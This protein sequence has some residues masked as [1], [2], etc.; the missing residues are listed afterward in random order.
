MYP[1]TSPSSGWRNRKINAARMNQRHHQCFC[2]SEHFFPT[3]SSFLKFH[4]L[5]NVSSMW[6]QWVR[7]GPLVFHHQPLLLFSHWSPFLFCL[8]FPISL[9]TTQSWGISALLSEEGHNNGIFHRS[10]KSLY[11]EDRLWCWWGFFLAL[12]ILVPLSSH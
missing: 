11:W 3:W 5:L 12:Y 8:E 9:L 2:L 6:W 1:S 10:K 4:H 7:E